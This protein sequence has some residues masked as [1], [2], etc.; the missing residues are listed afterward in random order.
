RRRA[1]AAGAPATAG[2]PSPGAAD[3]GAEASGTL[4]WG[5]AAGA[6]ERLVSGAAQQWCAAGG[7][8]SGVSRRQHGRADAVLCLRRP[9][10]RRRVA[11]PRGRTQLSRAGGPGS[12]GTVRS[13]P[14]QFCRDQPAAGAGRALVEVADAAAM[15]AQVQ[16]WLDDEVARERAGEAGRKVV[17]ANQGALEQLLQGISRLL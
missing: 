5:G 12:A 3:P 9:G 2:A 14:V 1:G 13:A 16:A 15:V 10:L 11:Y 8:R 4:R 7:G 17:E 6:A